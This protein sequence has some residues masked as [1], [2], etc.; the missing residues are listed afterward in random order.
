MFGHIFSV[1]I[2]KIPIQHIR[3][4]LHLNTFIHVTILSITGGDCTVDL[5]IGVVRRLNET[6]AG[7]AGSGSG[8]AG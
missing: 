4:G 8:R 6:E 3:R 7:E 2:P 1:M 5:T